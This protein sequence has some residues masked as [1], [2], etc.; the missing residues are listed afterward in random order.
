MKMIAKALATKKQQISGIPTAGTKATPLSLLN[1]RETHRDNKA[2][3]QR[4]QAI[5]ACYLFPN[6]FGNLA[7]WHQCRV[8]MDKRALSVFLCFSKE[9]NG[10]LQKPK[11][12]PVYFLQGGQQK[13]PKTNTTQKSSSRGT[14]NEQQAL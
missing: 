14:I 4:Q 10:G 1:N 6:L 12:P 8:A 11:T 3:K 7:V 5:T 13:R 9:E 2:Q